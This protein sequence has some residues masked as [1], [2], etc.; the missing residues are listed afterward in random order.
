MNNYTIEDYKNSDCSS[1]LELNTNLEHFLS[2]MNEESL[3]NILGE[4]EQCKVVRVDGKVI[5]FLI[6]FIEGKHYDSVNY[7]WFIQRYPKFLYIDRVVIQKEFQSKGIGYILYDYVKKYA[8]KNDIKCLTAEI[9]IYP[10]ND[11]SLNF[12]KK[13]G[14][15]EVGTQ[16][17]L[18]KDKI[19]SLQL[20]E[21]NLQ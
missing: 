7:Q 11:K 9:D 14:F 16:K 1:V 10:K 15:K 13:Q 18:G 3:N 6:L 20:C 2:P 4:A 8:H 19:V 12:H 21:L 5:A 17:I